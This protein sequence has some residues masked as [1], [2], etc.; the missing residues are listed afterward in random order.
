VDLSRQQYYG[1]LL[2]FMVALC[3]ACV[4]LTLWAV[5][6]AQ[7]A[8]GLQTYEQILS[9]KKDFLRDTVKNAIKTIDRQRTINRETVNKRI[10]HLGRD[11]DALYSSSPTKFGLTLQSLAQSSDITDSV[12]FRVD[13]PLPVPPPAKD[14]PA[15]R[16]VLD[17]QYGPWRVRMAVN[18]GWVDAQTKAGM[19][20]FIHSQTFADE[21]YLWVNEIKNWSGGDDYA[22]RLIHPN[23]PETEGLMLSTSMKDAEGNLPYLAELVGVRDHGELFQKYYFKR[24]NAAVAGEKISYS[25]AYMDYNWIVSMGVYLEDVGLYAKRAQAAGNAATLRLMGLALACMAALFALALFILSRLEKSYLSRAR[26]RFLRE[27]NTDHLTGALNRRVGSLYLQ[28]AF[29]E[30]KRGG[31]SP[32]L[33]FFDLDHF[34]HVNDSYGHEAGD[35]VLRAIAALVRDNMREPDRF[36]RWGGEEFVVVVFGVSH[37]AA[38]SHAEKLNRL[39]ELLPIVIGVTDDPPTCGKDL[40]TCAYASCQN[41]ARFTEPCV[42]GSGEKLIH[43]SVS[44]GVS[45]FRSSD[46]GPESALA[47]ADAA[48]YA[49]KKEG[50]NRAR[51]G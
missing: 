37:E 14:A 27:S 47:R 6:N 25:T 17:R 44:I 3:L 46:P 50:R 16:Y 38:I 22:V 39:V 1:F 5:R 24:L 49:A 8:Y 36:F 23:M 26:D 7:S 41:P 2:F 11:L 34:K 13:G 12:I 21:G 29:K 51:L 20:D 30:F 32:I 48:M 42:N 28:Q 19:A 31:A 18:E 40:E 35:R 10:Q 43:V 4:G 33:F 45:W 9:V 15:A